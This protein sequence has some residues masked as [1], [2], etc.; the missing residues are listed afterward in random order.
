MEP[1]KQ[2]PFCSTSEEDIVLKN[3][4]CYARFDKY[5][6]N[7]GHLLIIPFR[8]FENYF[9]ATKEEKI[10]FIELIEKAKKFLDQK[11]RPDGYNVGINIGKYAGQTVMH[12]HIHLIPRYR[13]DTPDPQGGVR[14]VIPEKQKY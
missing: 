12:V 2:C 3:D 9:D 5:P 11:F 1:L 6:V 4:L 10:A 14:G 7:K 8:H 13:G